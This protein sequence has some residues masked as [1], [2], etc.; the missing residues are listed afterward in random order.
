MNILM[1]KMLAVKDRLVH[2]RDSSNKSFLDDALDD[3]MVR[4]QSEVGHMLGLEDGVVV[5]I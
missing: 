5:V 2:F 4:P 1:N 3:L